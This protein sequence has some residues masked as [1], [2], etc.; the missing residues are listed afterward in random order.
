MF[1]KRIF[2]LLFFFCLS[3]TSVFSQK[4]NSKY[5]IDVNY[6]RGYIFL[7]HQKII[8]LNR[9]DPQNIIISW[10]KHTFGEKEWERA[11]NNPSYGLSFGYQ[12]FRNEHLGKAYGLFLNYTTYLYK[13]KLAL[14]IGDGLSYMTKPYNKVTNN[15]N[16]YI[17]TKFLNGFYLSLQYREP[18]LFTNIGFQTGILFSHY[19]N[20]K[21]KSPNL[22]INSFLLQAG[23]NYSFGYVKKSRP[24]CEKEAVFS[25]RIRY[26]LEVKSGVNEFVVGSGVKPFYVMSLY[27]NKRLSRKNGISVGGEY[28]I[29]NAQKEW[30]KYRQAFNPE[31]KDKPIDSKRVGVFI[32]HDLYFNK[33]S[34]MTQIGYYLY[35]KTEKEYPYYER[36]GFKYQLHK[37]IFCSLGLKVHIV[38]AEQLEFGIG[39]KL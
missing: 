18:N 1:L 10:N 27:A 19:S 39:I 28:F 16:L 9:N 36:I 7:H 6:A 12:D 31:W 3:V 33:L 29:S 38:K 21:V 14:Q 11:F 34:F 5:S 2:I 24:I 25:K 4:Q 26:N 35:N 23:V 20:G 37:N 22:G 17:G 30:L 15:K 8:Y 32:G 13:K